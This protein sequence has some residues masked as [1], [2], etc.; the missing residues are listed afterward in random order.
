MLERDLGRDPPHQ[1]EPPRAAP[2]H[3][4]E[5][6]L[7]APAGGAPLAACPA[8]AYGRAGRTMSGG[9]PFGRACPALTSARTPSL[10]GWSQATSRIAATVAGW[11]TSENSRSV[12]P[13]LD[14]TRTDGP[15]AAPILAPARDH[16]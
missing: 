5:T 14:W 11:V 2:D 4:R 8:S 12:R 7:D 1:E 6:R 3:T 9:G 13:S 15:L 10:I 16:T